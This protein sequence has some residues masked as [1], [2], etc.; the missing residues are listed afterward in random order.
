MLFDR[1]VECNCSSKVFII[2]SLKYKAPFLLNSLLGASPLNYFDTCSCFRMSSKVE[3][4]GATKTSTGILQV[5]D[6]SEQFHI[7]NAQHNLNRM[8]IELMA[9]NALKWNSKATLR[10]AVVIL[11]QGLSTL[12]PSFTIKFNLNLLA[13]MLNPLVVNRLCGVCHRRK[14]HRIYRCTTCFSQP[15]QCGNERRKARY[16]SCCDV[17]R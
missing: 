8:D 3:I 7:E 14:C 11:I 10:L 15:F 9:K 17:H 5:G 1:F 6:K 2:F 4:E 16:Y 12:Y 13:V